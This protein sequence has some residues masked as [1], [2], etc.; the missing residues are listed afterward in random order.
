MRSMIHQRIA[1]AV[2]D[3]SSHRDW[4]DPIAGQCQLHVAGPVAKPASFYGLQPK[5]CLC[6]INQIRNESFTQ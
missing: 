1:L 3:T 2:H 5:S 4:F 6:S